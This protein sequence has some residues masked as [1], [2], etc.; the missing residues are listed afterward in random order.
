MADSASIRLGDLDRL[1]QGDPKEFQ[2]FPDEGRDLDRPPLLFLLAGEGDDLLD[3]VLA[4]PGRLEDLAQTVGRRAVRF[5]AGQRQLGV[6]QDGQQDVVEIV[7][8]A[9]GQRPQGLHLLPLA[10]PLF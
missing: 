1:G 5:L 4:A 6:D 8:D 10:D 3:H 2:G 9:A 7:G